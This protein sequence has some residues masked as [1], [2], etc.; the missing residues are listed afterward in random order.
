M[1]VYKHIILILAKLV[2]HFLWSHDFSLVLKKKKKKNSDVVTI[3]NNLLLILLR[4]HS[5]A[6]EIRGHF[7]LSVFSL[8]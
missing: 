7:F 6:R 2:P 5:E 1:Y 8:T 4:Q 3:F